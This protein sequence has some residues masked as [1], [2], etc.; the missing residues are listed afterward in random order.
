MYGAGWRGPWETASPPSKTHP[1]TPL[2]AQGS[3]FRVQGSGFRV[4]D[5]GSRVQGLGSRV[6]GPGFMILGVDTQSMPRMPLTIAR[7]SS[8]E[9]FSF[10]IMMAA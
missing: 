4:L 7:D 5:L 3:G 8:G 2:P 1:L 10:G 6:Q 9:L